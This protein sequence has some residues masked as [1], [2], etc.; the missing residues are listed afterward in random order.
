MNEAQ[1][2]APTCP[3]G[4]GGRVV[5]GWALSAGE[6]GGRVG[7]D[8][9]ATMLRSLVGPDPASWWIFALF[10]KATKLFVQMKSYAKLSM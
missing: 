8:H 10:K 7:T 1:V 9:P 2:E 5:P 6:G 4:A 3:S